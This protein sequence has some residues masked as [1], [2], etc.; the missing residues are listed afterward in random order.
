ML[1]NQ[2]GK[3][4]PTKLCSKCLDVG[5]AVP[6]Q[7]GKNDGSRCLLH[8]SAK[9]K[10]KPKAKAKRHSDKRQAATGEEMDIEEGEEM[11]VEEEEEMDVEEGEEI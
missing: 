2:A 1:L 6:A 11:D 5:K 7:K 4:T 3:G 9:V 10:A 8:S